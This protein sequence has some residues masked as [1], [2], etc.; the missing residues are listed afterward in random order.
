LEES[1]HIVRGE[2]K[3]LM[4][5]ENKRQKLKLK[6][7]QTVTPHGN[8]YKRKGDM[9]TPPPATPIATYQNLMCPTGQ[10]LTHPAAGV[11]QEWATL[12]CPTWMGNPWTKEEI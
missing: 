3:M 12:G 8:T 2:T 4:Q 9:N 10:A 7:L 5:K 1:G 6:E 11:L